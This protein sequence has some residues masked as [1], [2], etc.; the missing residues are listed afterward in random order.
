MVTQE[1]IARICKVSRS[2]VCLVLNNPNHP[3]FPKETREKI[4]RVARE[5][6]YTPNTL[7]RQLRKGKTNLISLIIPWNTPELMDSMERTAHKL[8]YATMIQFTPEPNKE[9]E[10]LA[11]KAALERRA[12]GIIWMPYYSSL[13]LYTEFIELAK[14][15]HTKIVLLEGVESTFPN[16]DMVNPDM[17]EAAEASA[18]YV[19]EQ[20]YKK[21]T[22][23]TYKIESNFSKLRAEQMR[24]SAKR[25]RL[26]YELLLSDK[27]NTIEDML[28][29]QKITFEKDTVFFA[30]EWFIL[31][32]LNYC[33]NNELKVPETV[34]LVAL[35][36]LKLG[37]R[38]FLSELVSPTISAIRNF[39]ARLGQRAVEILVERL[40]SGENLPVKIEK[41]PMK[42]IP[43]E[44][45]KRK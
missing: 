16:I 6:N 12:D 38:F 32:I 14:R 24:E 9:A 41:I 29:N 27:P 26:E 1:T 15:T 30:E 22:Y 45:T 36:D 39:Y 3:E 42:F 11:L 28:N 25:F 21:I 34:G 13:E 17:E 31:D 33:K 19:A 23:I 7:A 20:G 35:W 5:L 18:R 43:R 44:S 10:K 2:A 4:L 37:N 8:G 40:R